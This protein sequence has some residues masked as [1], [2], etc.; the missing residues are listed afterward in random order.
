VLAAVGVLPGPTVT[1]R[2]CAAGEIRIA[3]IV[4]FARAAGSPGNVSAVCVGVADRSTGAAVLAARAAQLGTPAPRYSSSGLLCAIDG[5]PANGCGDQ[6]G[7][8]YKYWSY[9]LG[10]GS[11]TYASIGPAERRASADTV[12]GWRWVDGQAENQVPPPN[13]SPVASATCTVAP[14]PTSPP[15]TTAPATA[16]TQAPAPGTNGV[17]TPG[18]PSPNMSALPGETTVPPSSGDALTTTTAAVGDSTSA[19]LTVD[20]GQS[21]PIAAK[22][23]DQGS[24]L[25]VRSAGFVGATAV[26]AMV[27]I[28]G[29]WLARRRSAPPGPEP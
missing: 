22:H 28:G 4:D 17:T 24:N 29:M 1:P 26:I 12:E 8:G 16:T 6:S 7:A 19:P 3:V 18:P 2:A 20:G 11:W 10:T 5:F 27:V 14:P 21:D 13:G 23:D 15:V 9:W 25:L